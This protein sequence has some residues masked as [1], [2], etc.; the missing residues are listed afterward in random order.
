MLP[1]FS[2]NSTAFPP[3][4]NGKTHFLKAENDYAGK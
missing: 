1:E 4:F 2:L 3:T